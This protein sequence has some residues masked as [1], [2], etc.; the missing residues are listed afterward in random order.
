M[1]LALLLVLHLS[2]V[3]LVCFPQLIFVFNLRLGG[4]YTLTLLSPSVGPLQDDP[5]LYCTLGDSITF[6]FP[7]DLPT[8]P[9]SIY[10][11]AGALFP[12]VT[13]TPFRGVGNFTFQYV[14][15]D[16]L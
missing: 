3:V 1:L 15:I 8:H 5:D 6:V 7:V 13:G 9:F 11:T 14:L 10:T 12:G 16:C 2:S 4:A